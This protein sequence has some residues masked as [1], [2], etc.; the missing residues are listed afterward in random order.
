MKFSSKLSV[1]QRLYYHLN[2][3]LQLSIFKTPPSR[4]KKLRNVH[5]FI[6]GDENEY[7]GILNSTNSQKQHIE[8]HSELT[9]NNWV[10][11]YS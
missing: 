8:I 3:I 5:D 6:D 1:L 4:Q 9:T 10:K 2:I 11:T 7:F